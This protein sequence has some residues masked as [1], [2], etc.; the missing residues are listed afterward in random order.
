MD[1]APFVDV[2]LL[3]FIWYGLLM[4][5]FS[6]FLDAFGEVLRGEVDRL[7]C[8]DDA[9]EGLSETG[10]VLQMMTAMELCP[11]SRRTSMSW[12][13]SI[14][15]SPKPSREVTVRVGAENCCSC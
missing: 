15:C 4:N 7:D 1:F 3:S 8:P 2:P 13:I 10:S 6:F 9:S 14:S 5:I 11:K 12:S